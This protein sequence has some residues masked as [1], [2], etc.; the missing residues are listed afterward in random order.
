[1][2]NRRRDTDKINCQQQSGLLCQGCVIVAL[3]SLSSFGVILH[4]STI[5]V[6]VMRSFVSHALVV[7]FVCCKNAKIST[8]QSCTLGTQ[9]FEMWDFV[10]YWQHKIVGF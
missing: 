7:C 3:H 2:T 8:K 9:N 5:D 4:L 10:L 1:M 6:L